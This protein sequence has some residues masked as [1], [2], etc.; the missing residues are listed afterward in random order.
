MRLSR[1]RTET[2]HRFRS[3]PR[4]TDSGLSSG[5]PTCHRQVVHASSPR[6]PGPTFLLGRKGGVGAEAE[7]NRTVL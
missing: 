6:Q 1:E 7:V 4:A 3:P 5:P 2:L